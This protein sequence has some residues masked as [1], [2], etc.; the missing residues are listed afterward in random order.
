MRL[1]RHST[2]RTRWWNRKSR[3]TP[4]LSRLRCA[5][6][7][8]RCRSRRRFWKS[9]TD[10]DKE[11]AYATLYKVVTGLAKLLAPFIPFTTETIYQNLVRSVDED[12][13][14][15]IH[16][17]DWPVAD[18]GTLNHNLLNKMRLAINVASLGRSA[19]GSAKF[20]LRQVF[21]LLYGSCHLQL[22]L[23]NNAQSV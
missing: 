18:S 6:S 2:T 5:R 12:A 20:K 1:L 19:R 17:L 3:R 9:E 15:S 4:R 11:A 16:H 13:P 10:A 23:F 8:L 7:Q 22:V 21:A 14:D